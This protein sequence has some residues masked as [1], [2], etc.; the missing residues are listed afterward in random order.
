M[1][2]L[3]AG[4]DCQNSET[5]LTR[6]KVEEIISSVVASFF[7]KNFKNEKM[8]ITI[9]DYANFELGKF[10]TNTAEIIKTAKTPYQ[11]LSPKSVEARTSTTKILDE[12]PAD[13]AIGMGQ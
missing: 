12:F 13:S 3:W 7:E 10:D 11:Y 2:T 9:P 5:P 6:E 8:Q 1:N 4:N